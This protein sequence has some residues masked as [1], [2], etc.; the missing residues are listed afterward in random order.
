MWAGNLGHGR[1]VFATWEFGGK[2]LGNKDPEATPPD[3]RLPSGLSFEDF[4]R[5][6]L[7]LQSNALRVPKPLD[8]RQARAATVRSQQRV[9]DGATCGE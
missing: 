6:L 5:F 2:H 4:V 7:I 8:E 3:L 1:W 9:V